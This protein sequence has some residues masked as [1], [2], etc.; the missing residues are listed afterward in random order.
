MDQTPQSLLDQLRLRPD[1]ASWKRLV[2]LYTPLLQSWLRRYQVPAADADDLVQE[3]LAVLVREM[4]AFEHNH[5]CGAFRRWLRT[6]ALN[7][8]KGFW[9][10]RQA[11]P[12]ALPAAEAD[13]LLRQIAD[14]ASDPDRQ[15]E[16][17]HDQF[18]VRRALELLEPHFTPST[19][20]AFR[21]QILEGARPAQ[22]AAE[23]GLSANAVVLAKFRVLRRL[24]KQLQGL[25]D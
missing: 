2:D 3:V 16:Q 8:L 5:Q 6:I 21:R 22:V 23:L 17:E 20:Q 13:A 24:R 7:R 25:I 9:R 1:G 18:L 19:W 11:G 15:W 12:H 10:A 4:P 14:P